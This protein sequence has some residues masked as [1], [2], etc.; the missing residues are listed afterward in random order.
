[1]QGLALRPVVLLRRMCLRGPLLVAEVEAG[2]VGLVAVH[3]ARE[4]RVGD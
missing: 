4:G 2:R 1:M 3:G